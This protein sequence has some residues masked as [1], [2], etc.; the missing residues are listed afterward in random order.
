M[1]LEKKLRGES[2][3]SYF[4]KSEVMKVGPIPIEKIDSFLDQIRRANEGNKNT[5][6]CV[7]GHFFQFN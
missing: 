5:S 3:E 1:K 4:E 7:K 6:F 2:F